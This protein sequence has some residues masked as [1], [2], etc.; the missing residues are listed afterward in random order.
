[1][2]A[3]LPLF[4]TTVI[5][6]MPRPPFVRDLLAAR[7]R[8]GA[9]DPEWQRL[10]FEFSAYTTGLSGRWFGWTALSLQWH[11]GFNE[12]PELRGRY[13]LTRINLATTLLAQLPFQGE[14]NLHISAILDDFLHTG[15]NKFMRAPWPSAG[16]ESFKGRW[17]GTQGFRHE[18]RSS[19]AFC[20]GHAESLRARF[21]DNRDDSAKVA[22][23]TGFLSADNSLYDL[24]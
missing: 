22:A 11:P 13:G 23:G 17:S 21:T 6:S 9:P 18:G 15:T 12:N 5:G 7:P 16:D 19:A 8:P 10:F 2:S 4:P 1:M 14:I 24:E 3:P 20:D